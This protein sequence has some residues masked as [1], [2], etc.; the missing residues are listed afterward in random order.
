M[1]WFNRYCFPLKIRKLAVPQLAD[2]PPVKDLFFTEND[3]LISIFQDEFLDIKS[4]IDFY[5]FAIYEE[6]DIGVE[7]DCSEDP[8]IYVNLNEFPIKIICRDTLFILRKNHYCFVKI[9]H[10]IVCDINP[11][12]LILIPI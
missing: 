4:D 11:T 8:I 2:L 10:K 6:D 9:D 5:N 3:P 1:N 12:Y 7:N